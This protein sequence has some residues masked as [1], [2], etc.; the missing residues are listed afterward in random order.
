LITKI[1]NGIC[2]IFA[3]YFITS[4]ANPVTPEGGPKDTDPP[5][6]LKSD[7]PLYSKN[8]KENKIKITFNE[9]IQL[10]DVNKQ[11]IISPP[12]QIMS[13][14]RLKGKSLVIEIKEELKE[15]STYNIFFGN[16]I[17]DL[18]ENNPLVNFQYIF[19]TGNVIDSLSIEGQL[20][21]AFD[22]TP[23][24]DISIILYMDNND[25]IVFDSLPYFVKPYYMTKTDVSGNFSLKN[26]A[27]QSYKIFALN[28]MN[29]NLIYDQP[30]ESIAFADSLIIPTFIP[31][32]E[33]DTLLPDS[34]LSVN[35]TPVQPP[36]AFMKLALFQEI[37]SVQKLIKA[38][39]VKKNQVNLIFK[40]PVTMPDILPLNI[41][42]NNDWAIREF[43]ATHDTIIFWL[44]NIEQDSLILQVAD[45]GLV[46]DTAEIVLVKKS[47]GKK[48]DADDEITKLIYIKNNLNK[49]S[50]ELNQNL[51]LTF[52]YPL[53]KMDTSV[54][55]LFEH[56]TVPVKA[57]YSFS[58][59]IRRKVEIKYHWKK[60]TSYTFRFPDSAFFDIHGHTNDS[61][62]LSFVSKSPEDYGNLYLNFVITQE[63]KNYIIQ[64]LSGE[65]INREIQVT[66]SQRI[67]FN[68]LKPGSYKL[69]VI[70]DKNNNGKWDTGDY[71]YKILPEEVMFFPTEVVVR[72]NWDLEEDW[73]L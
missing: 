8:F 67:S 17:V 73:E 54:L 48:T 28:D 40:R 62:H 2:I 33:N 72:A 56:D 5:V 14:F 63:G 31:V 23:A 46:L 7:P 68:Y 32:V 20:F 26:L 65:K 51:M 36:V 71:I 12:M 49:N 37:D 45:N 6:F 25:T 66:D 19:S 16:A 64:L 61:T 52:G 18:T 53:E 69:K 41:P 1:L 35:Q 34:G 58:D 47:K 70:E 24:K 22:L 38:T 21:N 59:S 43:N 50:I 30:G 10:K 39:V 4:C 55:Q 13:D 44:K 15:N 9:F 57:L 42:E 60:S 29:G 11:V 3:G 27:N